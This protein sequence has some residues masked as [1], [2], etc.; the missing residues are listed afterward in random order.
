MQNRTRIVIK[1]EAERLVYGEVYAPMQIDTDGEAMTAEEIKKMAYKFLMEGR[2]SK[3]DVQHNYRESGC[4][5]VESFLARDNDPDGFV[6]GSWVLGVKIFPDELWEAVQKGELNG[7]SF[8][9]PKSGETQ[10]HAKVNIVRKMVGES[11]KS[12][13]GGLVPAHNHPI[14]IEFDDEGHVT[15]GT[16]EIRLG[17]AHDIRRTTATEK[18]MEHSHRLVL[19]TN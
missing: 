9:S 7:F 13:D 12:E 6:K 2:T 11:E 18:S 1:S 17:H 19:I 3:I 8:A 10:V 15:Q 16:T 5:V 4:A 14:D